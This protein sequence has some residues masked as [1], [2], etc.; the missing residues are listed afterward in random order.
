MSALIYY[1]SYVCT[2]GLHEFW[3]S[4][5]NFLAFFFASWEILNH[6][7]KHSILNAAESFMKINSQAHEAVKHCCS[8]EQY[9]CIDVQYFLFIIAFYFFFTKKHHFCFYQMNGTSLN[10]H[11]HLNHSYRFLQT[12]WLRLIS[13]FLN[14]KLEHKQVMNDFWPFT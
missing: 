7:L 2:N 11:I 13:A 4:R 10:C 5:L 1:T 3:R 14:W 6:F 8:N 9:P 12:S